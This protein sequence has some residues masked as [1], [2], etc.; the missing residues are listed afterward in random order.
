M[1]A[2]SE[3]SR[4]RVTDTR[5]KRGGGDGPIADVDIIIQFST[6]SLRNE[7]NAVYGEEVGGSMSFIDLMLNECVDPWRSNLE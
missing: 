3:F 2:I 1:G 4:V 5:I 6:G 7:W